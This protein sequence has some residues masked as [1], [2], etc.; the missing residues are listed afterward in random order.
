MATKT[1]QNKTN[2]RKNPGVVRHLAKQI[3][4]EKSI[5]GRETARAKALVCLACQ[6]KSKEASG[7]QKARRGRITA[8]VCVNVIGRDPRYP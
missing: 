7:A 8:H 1:K 6:R 3:I 4:W 5:P 2:K